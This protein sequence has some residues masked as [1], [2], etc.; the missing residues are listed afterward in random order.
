[1][2]SLIAESS[3]LLRVLFSNGQSNLAKL[4]FTLNRIYHIDIRKIL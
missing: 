3:L 4:Y 2:S 1:M